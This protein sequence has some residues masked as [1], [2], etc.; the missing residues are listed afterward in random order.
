MPPADELGLAVVG[1]LDAGAR[2]AL[3]EE[4]A[5]LTPGVAVVWAAGP[6]PAQAVAA[7][8]TATGAALVGLVGQ[9]DELE[10]DAVIR[11]VAGLGDAVGCYA[12]EDQI[13]AV[14]VASRPAR[15]PDWS[16]DLL[17]GAPY[18]GRPVL[19]RRATSSRRPGVWSRW[20]AGTGSTTWSC[21]WASGARWPMWPTSCTTAG[22][23]ELVDRSARRPS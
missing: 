13:D 22:R 21:G 7:A 23:P 9:H 19:V 4:L 8:V 5:E 14:G 18:V 17:L 10:P 1:R 11:L 6:T 2:R 3:D 15:K 20:T 16:P 12:D